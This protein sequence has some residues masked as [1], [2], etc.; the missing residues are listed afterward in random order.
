[1]PTL[2]DLIDQGFPG[3]DRYP[4]TYTDPEHFMEGRLTDSY[5]ELSALLAVERFEEVPLRTWICTDTRVGL[6][7]ILWNDQLVALTYQPARKS[8][9]LWQFIGSGNEE[10]IRDR[11]HEI[12]KNRVVRLPVVA[13]DNPLY[14]TPLDPTAKFDW[15]TGP[16]D[17]F[18]THD[19]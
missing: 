19:R 1:M 7:A 11:F 10:R 15:E 14:A 8:W 18:P 3:F 17:E 9:R 2:R 13:T 5:D 4:M 16:L 6:Y 12:S